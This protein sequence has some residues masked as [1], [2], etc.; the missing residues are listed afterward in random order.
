[1]TYVLLID[2]IAKQILFDKCMGNFH[3]KIEN[4]VYIHIYM[5]IQIYINIQ[6]HSQR[7]THIHILFLIT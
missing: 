4:T 6:I 2:H 1:M 3:L 7:N 5:H